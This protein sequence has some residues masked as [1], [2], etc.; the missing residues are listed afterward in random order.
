MPGTWELNY[1]TTLSAGV[2]P[3]SQHRNIFS[4]SGAEVSL[5][6]EPH[7]LLWSHLEL[8]QSLLRSQSDLSRTEIWFDFPRIQCLLA[9]SL[10]TWHM[11]DKTSS[12]KSP[13]PQHPHLILSGEHSPPTP[14]S[15]VLFLNS[16]PLIL[17]F[18]LGWPALFPTIFTG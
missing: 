3:S 17:L 4:L 12:G 15:P 18:L 8:V 2:T 1:L 7:T 9:W 10:A 16:G 11:G 5:T 6:F 13:L 14:N